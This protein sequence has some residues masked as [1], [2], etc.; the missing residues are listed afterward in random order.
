M[1][2]DFVEPPTRVDVEQRCLA[3]YDTLLGLDGP[4]A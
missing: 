1:R 3:D 4:V 2:F